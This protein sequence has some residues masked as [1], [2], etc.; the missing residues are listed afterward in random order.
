MGNANKFSVS[1]TV[2]AE[3]ALIEAL[4]SSLACGMRGFKKFRVAQ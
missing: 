4:S 1:A 2:A 3:G